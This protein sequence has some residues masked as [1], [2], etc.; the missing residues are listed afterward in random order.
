MTDKSKKWNIVLVSMF[1]DEASYLDEWICHHLSIGID[2]F[3]LFNNKSTDRS[4]DVLIKYIN[5][6]L[7]T[8]IDWP[9]PGAQVEAFNY[10]A[11]LYK[12]MSNWLTFID[13]DEFVVLKEDTDIH[14]FLSRFPES[15]EQVLIP[16]LNFGYSGHQVKSTA[17]TIDTFFFASIQEFVQTKHFVRSESL[18]RAGVHSS[19]TINGMAQLEDGTD[20]QAGITVKDAQY[21]QAQVNHYAT[22]SKMEFDQRIAKGEASGQ[23]NKNPLPFPNSAPKD[24]PRWRLENSILRHRETTTRLMDR[25]NRIA[26]VPHRYGFYT[27]NNSL[28]YPGSTAI[29]QIAAVSIGNHLVG[30]QIA[31]AASKFTFRAWG[32]TGDLVDVS[33][34]ISG[35]TGDLVVFEAA[36][37]RSATQFFGSVHCIDLIRRLNASVTSVA[38]VTES[39]LSIRTM[40][41]SNHSVLVLTLTEAEKDCQIKILIGNEVVLSKQ[42]QSSGQFSIM[43]RYLFHDE[44]TLVEINMDPGD[45]YAEAIVLALP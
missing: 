11:L 8:L 35:L 10:G 36:D 25:F 42:R 3:V 32:P 45:G 9:M 14:Q 20:V 34:R 13:T 31:Q 41:P 38:I 30:E 16:W 29:N 21:K 33:S 23:P 19:K 24:N 40:L 7:V 6:G 39:P 5:R 27:L 18:V 26:E 22:R 1:K 17:L 44:E 43:Y 37:V 15:I 4:R 28:A 12:R 2:H